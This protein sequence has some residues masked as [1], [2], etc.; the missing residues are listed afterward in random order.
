MKYVVPMFLALSTFSCAKNQPEPA[1]PSENKPAQLDESTIDAKDAQRGRLEISDR[2][3]EAC[4]ISNAEAYFAFNSSAVESQSNEILRKLADCFTTGP[5]A[6]TL[7]QLVGHA[8]PRGDNEYNMV[9]GGRR[10]DNVKKALV[11]LGSK[12][13]QLQ[14]TS[15]GELE[16][17]GT[18]EESW[19][20]DRRVQ[21]E[22][23]N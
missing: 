22:V 7:I 6:G 3:R 10:A 13:E 5:L 21:I 9:L 8:D 20:R 17:M 15:R 4:G 12:A 18:D 11:R 1:T 16:A 14:T 19:A 23:A 2:I